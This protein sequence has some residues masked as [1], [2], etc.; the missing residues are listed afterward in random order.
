VNELPSIGMLTLLAG[1]AALLALTLALRAVVQLRQRIATLSR[2]AAAVEHLALVAEHTQAMVCIADAEGRATW[3]NAAFEACTGWTLEALGRRRVSQALCVPATRAALREAL[4]A[5]PAE[6]SGLRMDW[7]IQRRDGRPM[8]L[9]ADLRPLRNGNGSRSGWIL[10]ATDISERMLGQRKLQLL[11]AALPAGVLVQGADGHIIDANAAAARLLGLEPHQVPD[12]ADRPAGWH[13]LDGQGRPCELESMPSHR[14][15]RSGQALHNQVVGVR[16]DG[17]E[18]RWLLVNTQPLLDEAT[19]PDAGVE[20]GPAVPAAGVITCFT[21]I[22][23]TRQLQDELRERARTDELTRL[24]NRQAVGERIQRALDHAQRHAGYGFAVLFMDFDR[25]KQVNDTL[26]HSAGDELLRLIAARL[27]TCL[28]PGD[29]LARVESELPLAARL[30]GDE[31]VVV[32]DG[33]RHL[34]VVTQIADRLLEELAA[35]YLVQETP[36]S[37]TASIGIVLVG[38]A[39]ADVGGTGAVGAAL[40]RAEEVLRDADT[41][42]YEAKRA[43]RGRWVVFDPAMHDRVLHTLTTERELRGA[44]EREELFVVYQPV[45]E[46]PG[47]R[48]VGAEALVRWRHPQRGLVSPAEFV[49][50]AEEC[51]LIEALGAFVLEQA[52]AQWQAWQLRFGAEAPQTLAVNLSRAQLERPGLAERVR[53]VLD[54]HGLPAARLQLEVTE[55]LAASDERMQATLRELKALGVRLALDD[56]GTG[57]SSLACL[58]QLPVDTVKIDRSFVQHAETVE[59]HR[60]LIEATIRVARTLGMS[61][62]AEGIETPGQAALMHELRCTRGQGWLFG[63]PMEAEA[64]AAWVGKSAERQERLRSGES[65]DWAAT[66]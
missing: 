61:T 36:I 25:F 65:S 11:W 64:F 31:F 5:M 6:G 21:D 53:Q 42:M 41:A 58:H 30:G 33:V 38:A 17:V 55:S 47:A 23:A 51:G 7:H 14:T 34:G 9:D 49:P 15:L 32:L 24:P 27:Q 44:L 62:V 20:G 2:Q 37:C 29:G 1:P 66:A 45:V 16:Q 10:V 19:E 48:P 54:R 56:F 13:L 4:A 3:I 59:Y 8:W 57:Y 50:V 60:V 46:L 12:R 52:V 40:P 43:G 22:T 35:P 26:G 39:V 18:P 63:K 28:R